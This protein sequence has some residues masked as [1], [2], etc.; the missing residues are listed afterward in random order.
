M[1]ENEGP[2]EDLKGARG[3]PPLAARC[4]GNKEIGRMSGQKDSPTV[5]ASPSKADTAAI[6]S[7]REYVQFLVT[8]E[9]YSQA[10]EVRANRKAMEARWK[11]L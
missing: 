2:A 10:E 5:A 3:D 8:Q 11:A 7:K 1:G 6:A 4:R 9:K